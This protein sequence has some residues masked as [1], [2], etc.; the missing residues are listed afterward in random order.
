M[1]QDA[2]E[3][4]IYNY[5]IKADL[6]VLKMVVISCGVDASNVVFPNISKPVLP[7]PK[8]VK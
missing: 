8:M 6:H 7:I 5:D 4:I 2:T 3:K 1:L